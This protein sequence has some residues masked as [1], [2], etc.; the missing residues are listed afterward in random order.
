VRDLRLLAAGR[1]Y[2]ARLRRG[3]LRLEP[4]AEAAAWVDVLLS[5]LSRDAAGN[6]AVRS[7]LTHAGWD[8]R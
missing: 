7:A 5:D 4:A 1:P 2:R 3:Q 8:L 6:R